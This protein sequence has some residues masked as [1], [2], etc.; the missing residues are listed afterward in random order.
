MISFFPCPSLETFIDT[1]LERR[2]ESQMGSSK[3]EFI[4]ELTGTGTAE[5]GSALF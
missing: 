1:I 3:N 5:Q 4:K 2:F